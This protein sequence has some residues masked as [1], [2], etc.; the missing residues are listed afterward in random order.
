MVEIDVIW[1][2]TELL[3]HK[4]S[5]WRRMGRPVERGGPYYV[6]TAHRWRETRSPAV[7]DVKVDGECEGEDSGIGLSRMK[8]YEYYIG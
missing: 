6:G 5:E 8:S 7:V 4:V 1:F 2:K 3:E